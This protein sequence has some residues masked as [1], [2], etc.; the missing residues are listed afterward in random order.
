MDLAHSLGLFSKV[1]VNSLAGNEESDDYLLSN[2]STVNNGADDEATHDIN[3]NVVVKSLT[4]KKKKLKDPKFSCEHCEF[5]SKYWAQMEQHA[6]T[7]HKDKKFTCKKCNFETANLKNVKLHDKH[8]HV[9][10]GS[11]SCDVCG[12][13]SINERK[14]A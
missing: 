10:K 3:S 11:L 1:L 12:F 4:E 14:L 13:K 6:N 2:A 9:G 7:V 5:G 8:I